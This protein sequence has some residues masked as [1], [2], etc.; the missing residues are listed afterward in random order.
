MS[1]REIY[2]SILGFFGDLASGVAAGLSGIWNYSIPWDEILALAVAAGS[3]VFIGY[4]IVAL[5][6]QIVSPPL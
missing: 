5:I 6:K 1:L 4:L 3:L 2:H